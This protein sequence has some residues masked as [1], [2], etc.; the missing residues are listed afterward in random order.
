M[1]PHREL[2]KH[3]NEIL[4][5]HYGH[6]WHQSMDSVCGNKVMYTHYRLSRLKLYQNT[7]RRELVWGLLAGATD[8]PKSGLPCPPC[9][10]YV[11]PRKIAFVWG[12]LNPSIY[13]WPFVLVA[14]EQWWSVAYCKDLMP[15]QIKTVSFQVTEPQALWQSCGSISLILKTNNRNMGKM[16]FKYCFIWKCTHNNGIAGLSH[17]H[18]P[19]PPPTHTPPR[20][21]FYISSS[22]ETHVLSCWPARGWSPGGNHP[23]LSPP[24]PA[25]LATDLSPKHHSAASP[26]GQETTQT[27]RSI[28]NLP[29]GCPHKA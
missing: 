15:L 7:P 19:P 2:D 29:T 3:N 6:P 13:A 18:T 4:A 26:R 5:S 1:T 20:A 9:Q 8:T 12:H 17:V 27:G 24:L 22:P 25:H 28:A 11:R 23:Q 14:I 16:S 21:D 10:T